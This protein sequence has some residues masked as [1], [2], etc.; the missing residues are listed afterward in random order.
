MNLV[1]DCVFIFLNNFIYLFLAVL[2]VRC[3]TGFSVV[4]E[5]RGYS[6]VAVLGLLIVVASRCGAQALELSGFRSCS[7][8][9]Q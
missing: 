3:Y 1:L 2:D 8:W 7:T 6:L 5:S 9:A 4:V